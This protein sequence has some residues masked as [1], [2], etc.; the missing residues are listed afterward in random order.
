MQ[1]GHIR[2]FDGLRISTEHLEHFQGS[3]HSALGD[4][5]RILG[6]GRVHRGFAVT[7]GDGNQVVLQPGLAFDF[8]G[9]RMVSDEAITLAVPP[10]GAAV[11][12]VCISYA[13]VE[14][15]VVDGRATLVFDTISAEV[16]LAKLKP[17]ENTLIVATLT[18]DGRGGF[19]ITDGAMMA[20]SGN[21]TGALSNGGPSLASAGS[22]NGSG[23]GA[24]AAATGKATPSPPVAMFGVRQGVLRLRGDDAS[25]EALSVLRGA[26]AVAATDETMPAPSATLASVL[27]PLGLAA[28]SVSC[29]GAFEA[30]LQADPPLRCRG[31]SHGDATL[32]AGG[33]AQQCVSQS[34]LEVPGTRDVS[35]R[36]SA[37]SQAYIAGVPFVS[38]GGD[39]DGG[40]L[41]VPLDVLRGLVIGVAL[42]APTDTGVTV[43]CR[44]DWDGEVTPAVVEWLTAHAPQIT[45]SADLAWK[46]LG[47]QAPSAPVASPVATEVT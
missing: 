46:A 39:D 16:R 37:V 14:D 21:G 30:T 18:P 22:T 26:M 12:Y 17:G 29:H 19:G 10:L 33:V 6:L 35:L 9:N 3:L 4:V 8:A 41:A 5:R 20:T 45:W 28:A 23:S 7:R 44:L 13:Q 27:L 34:E 24:D 47:T 15:G 2:V 32:G 36:A 42:G 1:P 11:G 43:T 38:R 31:I 25:R 40:P